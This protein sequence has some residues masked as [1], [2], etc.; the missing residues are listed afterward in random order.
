MA[1]PNG[2]KG[3]QWETDS[4]AFLNAELG[5]LFDVERRVKEGKNDRGD[6]GGI[7]GWVFECKNVA[8]I[9][10][11]SFMAELDAEIANADAEHGFAIVKRRNKNVAEAYCVTPLRRL[12]A[13]IR[14][15]TE[16]E[17]EVKSLRRALR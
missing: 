14:R 11:G 5:D 3:S 17:A 13:L 4:V 6:I 2:R 10:L 1:N 12:T 16:L 15:V 7:R 8:S 9:T